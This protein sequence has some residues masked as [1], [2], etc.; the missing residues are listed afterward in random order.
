MATIKLTLEE[1]KKQNPEMI[2]YSSGNLWWTHSED[3]LKEATEI[4]G[5]VS[6]KR[7]ERF[8]NDPEQKEEE[9]KRL[10]ALLQTLKQHQEQYG[11]NIPTDPWGCPLF[12]MKAKEWIE[13]AEQK[14][15]HFGKYGLE[16]FMKT[17]HQNSK[18][19]GESVSFV[20]YNEVTE[21]LDGYYQIVDRFKNNND[22]KEN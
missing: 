13:A 6:E 9:K 1:L 18:L 20:R 17:H 2:Y 8:L 16:A 5:L 3:D 14:P 11:H 15:E 12:M 22:G 7:H 4:G 21:Y 10:A 19:S